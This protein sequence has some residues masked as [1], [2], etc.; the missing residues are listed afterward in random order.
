MGLRFCIFN[1]HLGDSAGLGK[2]NVKKLKSRLCPKLRGE[3]N[4]VHKDGEEERGPLRSITG[5][6]GKAMVTSRTTIFSL[7]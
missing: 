4:T 1:N 3:I 7:L 5:P 6:I 2:Q